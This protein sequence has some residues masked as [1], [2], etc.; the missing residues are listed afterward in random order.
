MNGN[1]DGHFWQAWNT[2]TCHGVMEL[3]STPWQQ[4][5]EEVIAN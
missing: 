4:A 3:E 5:K 1:A 2:G